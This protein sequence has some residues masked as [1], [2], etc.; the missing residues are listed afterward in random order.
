MRTVVETT[1]NIMEYAAKTLTLGVDILDHKCSVSKQKLLEIKRL[2]RKL[3]REA[4]KLP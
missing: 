4:E 2:I 3:S 1:L